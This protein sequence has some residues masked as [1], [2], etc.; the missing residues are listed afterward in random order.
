M[1]L[2]DI[3]TNGMVLQRRKPIA[4]FGDG[5]GAG[6][7]ELNGNA[8]EFTAEDGFLVHLPPMEA[9]GPYDMTVTLNGETTLLTMEEKKAIVKE[10]IA[11]TKDKIPVFFGAASTSATTSAPPCI[12]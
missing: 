4:V 11:M 3:F 10:V 6:R 9:G 2:A 12:S 7:I 5:A 1:K 8:V